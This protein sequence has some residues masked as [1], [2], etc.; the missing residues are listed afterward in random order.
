MG[1][2]GASAKAD[3]ALAVPVEP[4][5]RLDPTGFDPSR[6]GPEMLAILLWDFFG[7]NEPHTLFQIQARNFVATDEQVRRYRVCANH[8]AESLRFYRGVEFP[9]DAIAME[10]RQRT[11]PEEGLDPKGDSAG[12]NE[13]SPN[14]SQDTSPSSKDE[15]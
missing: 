2:T 6:N 14:P 12:L 3:Q 10:A 4:V 15:T 11:D 9:E 7:P 1:D 13:A 8:I 5:S